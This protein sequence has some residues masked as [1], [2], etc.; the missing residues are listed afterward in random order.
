MQ[1]ALLP[2]GKYWYLGANLVTEIEVNQV[3][4]FG[5]VDLEAGNYRFYT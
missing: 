3:I 2:Y 5:G 1:G 4:T